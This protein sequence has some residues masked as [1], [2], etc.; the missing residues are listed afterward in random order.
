[1]IKTKAVKRFVCNGCQ[2][3]L[4]R[5]DG[6]GNRFEDDETIYCV[7]QQRTDCLHY[8]ERCVPVVDDIEEKRKNHANKKEETKKD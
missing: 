4:F 1:M 7:H 2:E 8:H 3:D 6:C 5:C